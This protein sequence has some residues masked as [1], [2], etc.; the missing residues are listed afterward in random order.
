MS[1]KRF[2][3]TWLLALL[4]L[5]CGQ[6]VEPINSGESL[7]SLDLTTTTTSTTTTTTT[8]TTNTN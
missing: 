4:V 1:S 8:T 7:A 6:P 3:C 5:S 2:S